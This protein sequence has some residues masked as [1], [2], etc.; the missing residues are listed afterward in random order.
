MCFSLGLLKIGCDTEQKLKIDNS[1]LNELVNNVEQT[2]IANNSSNVSTIQSITIDNGPGAKILCKKFLATND[3]NQDIKII[4]E[5]N[6]DQL[7]QLKTEIESS[8]VNQMTQAQQQGLAD[9]LA[10]NGDNTNVGDID[11]SVKNIVKNNISS[12]AITNAMNGVAVGQNITFKNLG[13]LSGDDCEF[14]NK[15]YQN[16]RITNLA[17]VL[18][19]AL[20]DNSVLSSISSYS[21]QATKSGTEVGDFFNL[22]GTIVG[23][24]IAV[25]ILIA[26]GVLLMKIFKGNSSSPGNGNSSSPG[27]G[28]K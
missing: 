26:I 12:T 17:K 21:S 3:L 8:I 28:K 5:F 16:I 1:I 7:A 25:G 20:A 14:V 2:A 18:Q 4:N 11:N 22:I 13:E 10:K 15:A 24:V 27:N 23:G 9:F 6:V 19:S